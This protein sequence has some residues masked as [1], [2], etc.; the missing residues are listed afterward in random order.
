V[1][2]QKFFAQIF[3]R[4]GRSARGQRFF[5]RGFQIFLLADVADHGNH[6]ATVRFPEPGNNN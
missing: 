2:S 4:R 5:L 6:F 3:D 1:P